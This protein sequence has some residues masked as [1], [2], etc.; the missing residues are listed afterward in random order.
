MKPLAR[1]VLEAVLDTMPVARLAL[2]D[3]DDAPEALPI[4]F[5]R[6][7][8]SLW[9]PIDG[10]PKGPAGQLGR[11]ARLERAPEAM[12]LLDHYADEWLDL[13]WIRLK[14]TTEII[15]GKHPDWLPAVNA[16]ATKYPQYQTTAMFKEAP[17]MLRFTWRAMS[18]WA[19]DGSRGV[20]RWLHENLPT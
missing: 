1:D 18:W 12:L 11:L 9:S 10:K 3:L 13:W 7:D 5:A 6:V 4:V 20:E 2:R 17:T 16:L 15:P 8:A 19:A 14:A